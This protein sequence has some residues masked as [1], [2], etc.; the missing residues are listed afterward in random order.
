M[1]AP[2]DV[3]A[4]DTILWTDQRETARLREEA[5]RMP[6]RN[7][8][9]QKA[10]VA[11]LE[12]LDHLFETVTPSTQTVNGKEPA[13]KLLLPRGD[14]DRGAP[15]PSADHPPLHTS[16]QSILRSV[17]M[18]TRIEEGRGELPALTRMDTLAACGRA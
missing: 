12:D 5:P 13:S 11:S 7:P 3:L 4:T 8:I 1:P 17:M 2:C 18:S 16:A 6:A 15:S 10:A 9:D 14:H